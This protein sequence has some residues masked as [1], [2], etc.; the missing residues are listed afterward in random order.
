MLDLLCTVDNVVA[1]MCNTLSHSVNPAVHTDIKAIH[2]VLTIDDESMLSDFER[3]GEREPSL[4]GGIEVNQTISLMKNRLC[5]ELVLCC[6][7]KNLFTNFHC[8]NIQPE[9]EES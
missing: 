7:K 3:T 9:I 8:S 6:W 5:S 2:I 1:V 4:S